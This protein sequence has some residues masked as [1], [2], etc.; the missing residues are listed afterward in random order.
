MALKLSYSEKSHVNLLV[1]LNEIASFASAND[2]PFEI[3][4]H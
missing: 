3:C 2:Q 4:I 1:I